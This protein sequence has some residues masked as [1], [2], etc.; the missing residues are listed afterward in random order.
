MIK[1]SGDTVWHSVYVRKKLVFSWCWTA[2]GH[3]NHSLQKTLLQKC[4]QERGRW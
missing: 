1:A 2:A 4:G 3:K